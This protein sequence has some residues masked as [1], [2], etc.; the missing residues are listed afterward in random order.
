MTT[1]RL[2]LPHHDGALVS[3][4]AP[5]LGGTFRVRVWVPDASG[6]TAVH[7]R[8]T[9]D[10][11]PRFTALTQVERDAGGAWWAADLVAR[12]PVTGYRFLVTGGTPVYRWLT[13]GGVVDHDVPDDTDF[14]VATAPPPADWAADQILYQ[15]FPDRFARSG[16]VDAWP[17]W[18][19]PA[20]W[21]D[22]VARTHPSSMR[23]L[24]GGDLHG[25]TEHL[26]HLTDLGVTGLYLN[27]VF[28]APENHRYCASSFDG[29]DPVLGGDE[30][31]AELTAA[32]HERGLRVIGDLTVNHS[33][34][35]HPWFVTALADPDAT[36]AGFYHWIEHPDRYEAWVGVPSLPKFDHRSAELRRRLYEGPDSVVARWLR[37]PFSLDGWRVDAANMT[38]R[39]RDV[40]ETH[41]VAATTLATM[42]AERDDVYLLAEHCHDASADLQGDGWHGTMNY[43]G[44]TRPVWTWLTRSDV[45]L[46]FLGVPTPVPRLPGT[47]LAATVD[48]FASRVP[49]RS[50][51]HSLNLLG[52]HD[53]TRWR[54]VAPD[55]DTA[56][57]GV[58]M[59]L[60]FP[61]I[62]SILY[63]DEIGLAGEDDES[64]REPF[65]W[66]DRQRWDDDALAAYRALVHLRREHRV[67]RRGGFRWVVV[68]DDVL[69][70]LREDPTERLLVQVARADHP[71]VVLPPDAL[72]A[73][74]AE[75]LL[76]HAHPTATAAG[77]E[78]PA[79]G[80][81]HHVWRLT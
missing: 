22:P 15:V 61:G 56:L 42:R 73:T 59:L 20:D 2:D 52:S 17:D 78:L 28:P 34:S 57:V 38:G 80:P 50:R 19:E 77:L 21:D 13:Q 79:D 62:P 51:L 36:E 4:H 9:P 23:Q 43:A 76:G 41:R 12:N 65:P 27:P 68:D 44:F 33:G 48:A 16:R 58:A 69:V 25:V 30:A 29:V 40:D 72:G 6:A 35:T 7:A 39:C 70:Y 64:A 37:P 63:G 10:G 14:R 32:A 81:S 71:A 53:T 54:Y 47:A 24:Y 60:T 46:D 8:T 1:H 18:A 26:D 3:D 67:L 55:L 74:R 11:E 66:N 45:E 49:W 31:L 75:D 5:S